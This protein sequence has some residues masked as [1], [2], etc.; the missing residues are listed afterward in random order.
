MKKKKELERS[1]IIE[2]DLTK[3]EREIQQKLREITRREREKGISNE[4]IGYKK[5]RVEEIW[6][7]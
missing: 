2:D 7:R 3:R 1:I 5:I 4:R 6:Y